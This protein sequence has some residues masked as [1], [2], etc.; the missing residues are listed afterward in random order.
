VRLRHRIS[1][2]ESARCREPAE[3]IFGWTDKQD[4]PLDG[5]ECDGERYVLQPDETA[6]ELRSRIRQRH[7]GVFVL[8]EEVRGGR[9][10]R[11]RYA[12][13]Q[14]SNSAP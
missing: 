9:S 14:E 3:L 8:M 7:P 6:A 11:E 4:V 13:D 12:N 2:L 5:Y 1:R 10:F